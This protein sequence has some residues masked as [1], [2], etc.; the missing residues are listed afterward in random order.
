MI[1]PEFREMPLNQRN[2]EKIK[3]RDDLVKEPSV[4]ATRCNRID[5]HRFRIH[6][7]DQA[8]VL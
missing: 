8:R 5:S 2:E 4:L 1:E 6:R 7:G 3:I